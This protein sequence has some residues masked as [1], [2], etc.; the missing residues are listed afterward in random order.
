MIAKF[1]CA[2]R[3]PVAKDRIDRFADMVGRTD[4]PNHGTSTARNN[5][6]ADTVDIRSDWLGDFSANVEAKFIRRYRVRVIPRNNPDTIPADEF[7]FDICGEIA[8]PVASN[9][10]RIRELVIA[11]GRCAVV[12][13]IGS[14]DHVGETI[15]PI[16]RDWLPTSA[17]ELRDH[18]LFFHYLSVFP[19]T[20]QDEWQT[21]IYIPLV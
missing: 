12:R 20:P 2:C 5:E 3:K 9:V 11:G 1:L 10:Y 16:F 19:E 17:E 6:F 7:R 21:D 4:M 18:P 13:H 8:E 14:T 15:Y